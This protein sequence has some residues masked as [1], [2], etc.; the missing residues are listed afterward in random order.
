MVLP[1]TGPQPGN[2]GC[3]QVP[4]PCASPPPSSRSR[5][6]GLA[7]SS[8]RLAWL[9]S[10]ARR[11]PSPP[12]PPLPGPSPD[13][14]LC[15]LPGSC[16]TP[17]RPAPEPSITPHWLPGLCCPPLQ[18]RAGV[19]DSSDCLFLALG[20]SPLSPSPRSSW[21][22]RHDKLSADSLPPDHCP[23]S[24]LSGNP[25]SF[26]DVCPMPSILGD[27]ALSH[28]LQAAFL[29]FQVRLRPLCLP[30]ALGCSWSW[31]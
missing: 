7:H 19:S 31:L 6:S 16:V 14:H 20:A 23:R 22:C 5:W 17:H 30:L 24:F 12:D 28:L 4:V 21:C 27:L 1:G 15:L 10:T 13:P 18:P 29:D 25:F 3:S 9:C 8:A 11:S 26:S 2:A